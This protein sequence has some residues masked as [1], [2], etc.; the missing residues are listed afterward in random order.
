VSR[1]TLGPTQ[2]L[3]QRILGVKHPKRKADH[4]L[5]SIAGIKNTWSYTS[6]PHTSSWCGVYLI[7]PRNKFIFASVKRA[8]T[9]CYK[10]ARLDGRI[11][12]L[13]LL[14][15]YLQNFLLKAHR[16]GIRFLDQGE[17]AILVIQRRFAVVMYSEC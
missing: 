8:S 5:P 9:M 1:P 6:T 4:S 3:I 2:S 13:L 14:R 16:N 7:K 10:S 11:V 12:Q 17:T 15:V